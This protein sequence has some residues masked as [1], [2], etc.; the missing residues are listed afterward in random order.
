[1]RTPLLSIAFLSSFLFSALPS[2]ADAPVEE[3]RELID[4]IARRKAKMAQGLMERH[5]LSALEDVV[6]FAIPKPAAGADGPI[7]T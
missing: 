5:I 6:R 1:M 3:H 7:A 2:L 4:L